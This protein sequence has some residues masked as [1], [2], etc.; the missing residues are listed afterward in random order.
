MN[1]ISYKDWQILSDEAIEKQIGLYIRKV[2]LQQNK[3]QEELAKASNIS[4]STLSLLERG[5]SGNLRT[6]IQVLR[7]L[8]KLQNF[9][10]FEYQE[11]KSPLA[12][13]KAEHK[14]RKRVRH[15]QNT[16]KSKVN[17]NTTW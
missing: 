1:D 17:K 5:E 14:S 7:M 9:Q 15:S 13:A 6:L 12:L 11:P 16:T 8:D 4:R 2:R 10:T 3:T